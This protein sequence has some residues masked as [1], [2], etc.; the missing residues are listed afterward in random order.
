MSILPNNPSL[1][2]NIIFK[3]SDAI[4]VPTSVVVR[5][6]IPSSEQSSKEFKVFSSLNKLRIF[7]LFIFNVDGRIVVICPS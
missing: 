2:F 1:I 5:D 4:I 7:G 3:H 6:N